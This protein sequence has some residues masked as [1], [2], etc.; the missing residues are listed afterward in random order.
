M[1]G[2]RS[3]LALVVTGVL[4]WHSSLLLV[5][6][7]D[8]NWVRVPGWITSRVEEN[9]FGRLKPFLKMLQEYLLPRTV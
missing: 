8:L 2:T 7:L 6:V 3:A 9:G 4:T 1:V 5:L